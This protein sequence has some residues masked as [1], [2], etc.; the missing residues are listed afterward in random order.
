MASS[1]LPL[2]DDI[3][4]SSRRMVRELGFLHTT[5]AATDYQASA[6]HALLEIGNRKAMTAAQLG[7]VLGLEKSSVSRM[8]R[9]LIDAGELQEKT[10]SD[11]GRAK[12]LSLTAKG[13]K[14]CTAIQTYA[15]RQVSA[16]LDHL[17]PEQRSIVSQG[18][19]HYAHAL[20]AQRQGTP[21]SSGTQTHIE[22][23]YRPGVIGRIAE[24]HAHFYS[25]H[26]GF[27]QFFESKVASGIAEFTGRLTNPCNRL[28]IA[29]QGERIVGS[30]AIDG[31]DLGSNIAHLRW[32]IIDDGV[33][34]GG[35]GRRLMNEAMTFCD[36]Q[37]FHET[38]LWTFKG[39]D[40]ARKLYDDFGFTLAEEWI[41]DQWGSEVMEQMFVR[42]AK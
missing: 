40:A 5:L 4:A 23:G 17:P 13:R 26:T 12:L 15:R 28:W 25:R 19:S 41:G 18:L 21:P 16:A 29:L 24:M 6:V 35:V 32:F 10:S 39:L 9:K 27:G 34:G 30:I 14:T 11:D 8:V 38:Q 2:I 42:K 22:Q 33:R 31:E 7:E 20:E 1:D 37:G 3:R 36:T